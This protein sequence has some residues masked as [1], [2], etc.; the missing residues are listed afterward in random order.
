MIEPARLSAIGLFSGLSENQLAALAGIAGTRSLAK[1]Q[2]IFN[3]GEPAAGFYAVESG[4]VRVYKASPSGKEQILHVFGPGEVLG[5][6]AVFSGGRFPASAQALEEARLVFFPRERFRAL[7]QDDPDLALSMLG[8]LSARLRQFAAKIE[9]LS[10]KEVPARLAAHLL[11]L[12]AA[13]GRATFS[14]DLPK[15]MLASL[16]GTIPETLSRVM[17]KLCDQKIIRLE[18]HTVTMLD[19][20][21]LTGL[22]EGHERLG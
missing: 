18:G 19:E 5:E 8:L 12:E 1:G 14:L 6:A 15:G 7:L 20:E 21:A 10:L 2:I 13:A 22:A 4:Q 3:E 16:I 11:V 9:S 17:R